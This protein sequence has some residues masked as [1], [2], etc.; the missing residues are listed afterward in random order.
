MLAVPL[1]STLLA[2]AL[3][4]AATRRLHLEFRTGEQYLY[5]RVPPH[6]FQQLITAES[7]GAYFNR[8]I[9]NRFPFQHLSR[10]SAPVVLPRSFKY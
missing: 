2:S 7:K 6:C 4:D 8:Y 10:P 9:R 3:Y 1:D 5:F